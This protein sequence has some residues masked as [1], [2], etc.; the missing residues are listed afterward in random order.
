MIGASK[1]TGTPL[2]I[3]APPEMGASLLIGNPVARGTS[4][5]APLSLVAT[6]LGEMSLAMGLS[7][8]PAPLGVGPACSASILSPF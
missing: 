8:P 1:L 6:E 7:M 2:A 5:G 4:V 3:G